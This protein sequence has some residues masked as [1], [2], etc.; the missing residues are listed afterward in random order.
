MPVHSGPQRQHLIRL[1]IQSYLSQTYPRLE[2]IVIDDIHDPMPDS[3][4]TSVPSYFYLAVDDLPV[5]TKR[6]LACSYAR[7]QYIAHFD[8]DDLSHPDRVLRQFHLLSK[9]VP[10]SITGYHTIRFY[11]TVSRCAY[12][13]HYHS[14]FCVGT[15]LFYRHSYWAT[16]HFPD[17]SIAEDIPYTA[18]HT[19]DR[20]CTD[21]SQL[22]VAL[23]HDHNI[24]S[25]GQVHNHPGLFPPTDICRLPEF[26][27]DLLHIS[28]DS[29][30]P[31]AKSA[32]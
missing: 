24:S 18:E 17:I 8:S 19:P 2:L 28:P 10:H 29:D 27:R 23:L 1:A 6:N 7:G 15:S 11:D 14:N 22:M 21:G 20:F 25:R 5:G 12:L 9:S 30:K 13:Y 32:P 26:A 16:H 31:L 4:L 3:L